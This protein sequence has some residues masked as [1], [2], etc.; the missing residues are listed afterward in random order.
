VL[1]IPFGNGINFMPEPL[2]SGL[3]FKASKGLPEQ[4]VQA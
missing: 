3:L 2:N 4:N 1:K